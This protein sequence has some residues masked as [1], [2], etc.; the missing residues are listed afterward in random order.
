[1]QVYGHRGATGEA[2]E[3]TIAACLHAI[4]RGAKYVEI[5]LRLSADDQ[6]VVIHDKTLKRTTGERGRV[7]DYKAGDLANMDARAD[8]PPWPRKAGCGVPTLEALLKVTQ[9]LTGYQL[10]VKPDTKAVVRRIAQHLA[11]RFGTSSADE[12]IV[13]TSFDFY[14]HECLAELAPQI[15]R[16]L[17]IFRSE[18]IEQLK[19]LDCSYCVIPWS[20]CNPATIRRL[21]KA[22]IHISVWAVNDAQ[23]LKDLYQLKVDSVITAYPSMAVP[24]VATLERQE[25]ISSK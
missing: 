21:R 25:A 3:N 23:I 16:G 12:G 1:M 22:G 24:L 14:L 10:E 6:L 5:D 11:D 7:R 2:P 18:V 15:P 17:V 19:E 4:E 9:K 8:G 20:V 13:V